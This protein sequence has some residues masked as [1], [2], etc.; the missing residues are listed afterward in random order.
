MTLVFYWNWR[1][2]RS[3][4]V[5]CERSIKLIQTVPPRVLCPYNPSARSLIEVWHQRSI[6]TSQQVLS[7]AWWLP[8][9]GETPNKF[10][11]FYTKPENNCNSARKSK[12][13]AES[14]WSRDGF[15]LSDP[16]FAAHCELQLRSFSNWWQWILGRVLLIAHS[17]LQ[18][19]LSSL[20]ARLNICSVCKLPQL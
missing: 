9:F 17:L 11:H 12:V 6:K 18:N 3:K 7:G 14:D 20:F 16:E 15:Q 1:C 10:V 8:G 5:K 2:G 19:S 4:S 13:A